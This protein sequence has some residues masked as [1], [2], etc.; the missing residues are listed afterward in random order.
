MDATTL[1]HKLTNI[2]STAYEKPE[3]PEKPHE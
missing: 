1:N 2:E 3:S